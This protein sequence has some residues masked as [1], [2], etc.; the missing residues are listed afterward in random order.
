MNVTRY[1]ELAE[2]SEDKESDSVAELGCFGEPF[3]FLMGLLL[4]CFV[5][6]FEGLQGVLFN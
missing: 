5:I 1:W 2:S 6:S 3:L 4:V